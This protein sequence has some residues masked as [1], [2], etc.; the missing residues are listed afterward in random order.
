MNLVDTIYNKVLLREGK[1]K[2]EDYLLEIRLFSYNSS[3][4]LAQ[5]LSIPIP[6][7]VAIKKEL[8][9]LNIL[10]K[11]SRFSLTKS[12]IEIIDLSFHIKSLNLKHYHYLSNTSALEIMTKFSWLLDYFNNRPSADVTIDQAKCTL[13]SAIKRV[14]YM[15]KKEKLLHRNILCLGDDD[16][17]SII[18]A[19][20]NAYIFTNQPQKNIHVLDK[21][22]RILNYIKQSP[23]YI[24]KQ[25]HVDVC[26]FR[27]T[28]ENRFQRTMDIVI[29]DPPYT[30]NG[31]TLFLSRAIL[32]LKHEEN[33][34]CYIS[35]FKMDYQFLYTIQKLWVENHILLLDMI[36]GF[37]QYEGGSILGS[38]SD[39]Y[40]LITTNKTTVPL[41]DNKAM[42]YTGKRNPT[43]RSYQ[44]KKCKKIYKINEKSKFNT[45]E[46][47][48]KEGCEKCG[49]DRFCLYKRVRNL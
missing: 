23:P 20:F 2:I 1:R 42:I 45:I 37:N 18:I 10:E 47:L 7:I 16:C 44:C 4:Q 25:I 21:D 49:G 30:I 8:Q 29:M 40:H 12:G 48:K 9:S 19:T 38:Q 46:E 32:C 28:L 6:I 41:I 5:T 3:K 31:I 35:F 15:L 43:T 36:I 13:E 39:F 14:Q 33:L 26:D 22:I 17:M 11:G 24:Q 34:S 27:D